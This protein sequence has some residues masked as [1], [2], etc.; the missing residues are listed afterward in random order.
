MT[1]ARVRGDG[2]EP[3]RAWRTGADGKRF[4]EGPYQLKIRRP[5]G[6]RG[7]EKNGQ[8]FPRTC[9]TDKKEA[10]RIRAR[11]MAIMNSGEDDKLG[12][13]LLNK[14]IDDRSFTLKDMMAILD[15]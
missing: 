7:T 10:Y 9:G 11:Y 3:F 6:A 4:Q 2:P 8:G 12:R 13:E 15:A 1:M 5:D 14:V